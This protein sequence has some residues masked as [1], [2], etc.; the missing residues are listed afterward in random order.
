MSERR[1]NPSP[2]ITAPTATLPHSQAV[3]LRRAPD[4]SLC[5]PA[6]GPAAVRPH[7]GAHLM[8]RVEPEF[9]TGKNETG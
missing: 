9:S 1:K 3:N 6:A 8:G 5:P 4:N 7:P 2:T